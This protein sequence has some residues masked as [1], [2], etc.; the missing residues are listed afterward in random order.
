MKKTNKFRKQLERI[1]MT[2][3]FENWMKNISLKGEYSFSVG[4]KVKVIR[5]P[6]Y[7]FQKFQL[8]DEGVVK[9]IGPRGGTDMLNVMFAVR[10]I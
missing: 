4:D 8:G 5:G 7:S 6:S 1:G 2:E 10:T 3:E 9:E